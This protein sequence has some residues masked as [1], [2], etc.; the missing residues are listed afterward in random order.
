MRAI[1]FQ[2]QFRNI[3][4]HLCVV[5]DGASQPADIPH[6]CVMMVCVTHPQQIATPFLISA[7][8]L[9][10]AEN[11]NALRARHLQT[12][13]AGFLETISRPH[14]ASNGAQDERARARRA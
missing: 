11:H 8:L 7:P 4:T 12:W 2:L 13:R 5:V 6:V 10:D 14:P 3:N 9:F 1:F